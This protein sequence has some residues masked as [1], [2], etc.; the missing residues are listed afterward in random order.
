MMMKIPPLLMELTRGISVSGNE[1][2]VAQLLIDQFQGMGKVKQSRWG[3]I[4]CS[5]SEKDDLPNVVVTAHMDSPGF[6]VKEILPGGELRLIHLGGIDPQKMDL[7]EVALLTSKGE[8]V[9]GLLSLKGEPKGLHTEYLCFIGA[10]SQKEVEKKGIQIGD[11]AGFANTPFQMGEYVIGPHLDNRIGCY[12][13]VEIGK[14]LKNKKLPFNLYLCGTTCEEMGGRGARILAN[15]LKPAVTICLDV[16]Y[17]EPPVAMGKGPVITLSDRSVLLS[18]AIRDHLIK[19]AKKA[20]TPLQMEV[21]NYAGTDA[22]GFKESHRGSITLPVLIATR[23]NHSP[24]EICHLADLDYTIKYISHLLK[25]L[26]Y[27]LT[28]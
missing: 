22:E 27:L 18:N 12:L 17:D 20:K 19:I 8:K 4:Y 2:E 11:R 28:L 26:D 24:H 1:K 3:D 10:S 25:N 16:T 15:L 7:R 5:L 23:N 13:M 14:K 9:R 21:Y 6:I